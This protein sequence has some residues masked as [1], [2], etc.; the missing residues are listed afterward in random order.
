[1]AEKLTILLNNFKLKFYNLKLSYKTKSYSDILYK[2]QFNSLNEKIIKIVG[3]KSNIEELII[4]EKINN[5]SVEIID[6]NAFKN[7]KNIKKIVFSN[8]ITKVGPFA[9]SGCSKLKE[10]QLSCNLQI[11]GKYCFYNCGLL[12]KLF[13][14]FELIKI[15][16][17]AFANCYNLSFI[18]H[19]L[20]TRYGKV[21]VLNKKYL[22]KHLPIKLS[23]IGKYA[24]LNCKNI[25]SIYLP[26][27]VYVINKG[28][29]K[30]CSKLKD[31]SLHNN[32]KKIKTEAFLG[33]SSLDKIKLSSNLNYINNKSFDKNIDIIYYEGIDKK[34]NKIINKYKHKVINSNSLDLDSRMIPGNNKSFYSDDD[35]AVALEKYEIRNSFSSPMNR[36]IGKLN[37]NKSK[38]SFEDG[39]YIYE[40]KNRKDKVSI[41]LTGDVMCRAYQVN[42][43]L[44]NNIYNFDESFE[45]I[46]KIIKKSD[47]AICNLETNVAPSVPYCTERNYVDDMIHMN[48]PFEFLESIKNA[49]FDMVVNS[50]NHIYDT[51]CLGIFETLDYLNK[52]Q[53]I[54]T[55]V[56]VSKNDK[57]HV[58][59]IINGINIGIVSYCN[60]KYQSNKR[61]NFSNIGQ[62]VFFSDFDEQQIK[63]DIDNAKKDGAEF[64]IAYCH[65]GNEYTTKISPSQK[66]FAQMVANNGADYLFGCHPHCLQ[67]YTVITTD[68]N[69]KVPC[70][71][72]AGNFISDMAVKLPECRDTIILELNLSRREDGK[73]VIDNECYYPCLIRTDDN[74]R[75]GTKTYLIQDLINNQKDKSELYS[76][77]NRI[78]NTVGKNENFKMTIDSE[79]KKYLYYIPIIQSSAKQI[80]N[81]KK[82]LAK[83]LIRNAKTIVK[84]II[85]QNKRSLTLKKICNICQIEMP[86]KYKNTKIDQIATLANMSTKFLRTNS[87]LFT[88]ITT[89]IDDSSL[90]VIKE[91]CSFIVSK[92]QIPGCKCII[93]EDP[94]EKAIKILNYIKSLNKITTISIT[95]SVGKTTTKDFISKVL[96]EKYNNKLLASKGNSNY[97]PTITNN[98]LNINYDTKIYLQEVGMPKVKGKMQI[99]AK[100]L[101]PDIIVYTNI[102]DAHIEGYGTREN[103]LREKAN[104]AKYGNPNGIVLI[105]YDDE[106]LRNYQFKQKKLSFSLNNPN[107]DFYAENIKFDNNT[108][109]SIFTIINNIDNETLKIKIN[110][111]GNHNI[112]NAIA[113]YAVG[114]LL[115][116]NNSIILRGLA[117][118]QPTCNR[119]NLI[120]YGQYQI[121]ADC[122][123]SSYDSIKSVIEISEL[124]KIN[125]GGK[126]IAVIG[127]VF[128]L[129]NHSEQIHRKIGKLLATSIFDKVIFYGDLVKYSYEEY[130]K[131][132]KNS[133]YCTTY[134]D[135][136]ENIKKILKANDLIVFKA[137]HGMHYS[138]LIDTLFG[139]NMGEASA[140]ADKRYKKEDKDNFTF[141]IYE[142][143]AT[144]IS[145]L[146]NKNKILL[147]AKI[148]DK[149]IEKLAQNLFKDNKIINEIILPK[150]LVRI[151]N[152][153]F[154]KSSLTKV[155]FNDNLK[156]ICKRA[157]YGCANLKEVYLPEN[158]ISIE[159]KAFANCINLMKVYISNKVKNI[160]SSVFLNSNN[161]VIV[162]HDDS[163]AKEYAINNNI[164]YEII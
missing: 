113:A 51:G 96:Y 91:R 73:V 55:G 13:L 50:N 62:E 164:K 15:E 53:L 124:I 117:K 101:E 136:I 43:A 2:E 63:Q 135:T 78:Q 147:P 157:F 110:A 120:K 4:P 162:C 86:K 44:K 6:K 143:K 142:H 85:Y 137:S 128:E 95:G 140:I 111:L 21:K 26:Y 126:K 80:K 47:L 22:E 144:A 24:Y 46:K 11:I 7:N 14:P 75:G 148:D 158:L 127:D 134:K 155:V 8:T 130:Q 12:E 57:R 107:A 139:F 103:I 19:Y 77:L 132:N 90:E 145:Y 31:V 102:K 149:P 125:D 99:M 83:R 98:I 29:F 37:K 82:N 3:I 131:E 114:K 122:Y 18:S 69:R 84:K 161:V 72:S 108:N 64:I 49:G 45:N 10:V 39:K 141:N 163:F 42:K 61:S 28:T 35:L 9:F 60:Q 116:I 153:C 94:M 151:D 133:I 38:L 123:N 59:I 74:I 48:A 152:S 81:R 104:L 16:K 36:E 154:E 138:E 34:I 87:I 23:Y 150:Y 33:C 156:K 89:K 67:N 115:N 32:I 71:F 5:L 68:D 17:Y 100:I 56:F 27:K 25:E 66:K 20:K 65:W 118:Y 30:N 40:A 79:T 93:V 52:F 70:L 160:D 97:I 1:M 41:M 105:N 76:D 88:N 106:L 121:F 109:I 58:N 129:G 112:L 146:K 54:H 119:Q 92:T 159:E